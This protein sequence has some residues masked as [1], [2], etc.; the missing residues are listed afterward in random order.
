MQKSLI[1]DKKE[2]ISGYKLYFHPLE[3]G[4]RKEQTEEVCFEF[5]YKGFWAVEELLKKELFQVCEEIAQ[6]KLSNQEY[7]LLNYAGALKHLRFKD[8]DEF[9]NKIGKKLL[10]RGQIKDIG[11]IF[12][13]SLI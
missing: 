10:K 6:D 11:C 7:L 1:K 5:D 9:F 2:A 8:F 12:L 3:E 4:S 13:K